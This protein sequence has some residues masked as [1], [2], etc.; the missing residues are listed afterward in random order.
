MGL[1]RFVVLRVVTT[2]KQSAD[3]YQQQL[4]TNLSDALEEKTP[5]TGQGRRKTC[6][7]TMLDHMLQKRFRTISLR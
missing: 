5:F 4:T 3:R 7:M 2:G 1:E 6:F